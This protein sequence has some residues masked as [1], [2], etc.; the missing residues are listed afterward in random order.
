VRQARFGVR[1]A[2]LLLA[3]ACALAGCSSLPKLDGRMTTTALTDTAD[4]RLGR[5]VHAAATAHP[6]KS[7]IFPLGIPQDAFAARVVLARAAER[8]LDVQYYIWHGDTTG[9]LLLEELWNAAER[10]VRVR[11]LVDDNGVAGLDPALTALDSH[12]NVEVRL[13]NPF[14][15]RSFKALGFLTDFDRL[16]RRMHN[17]SLTADTQAAIVGGRNVGDEYFGAGD[18]MVFADLDV[19][20]V[21]PVAREVGAAFDLYWNSE[22]V[23][24]AEAIIGPGKPDGVAAMKAKFA[25]VRDSAEAAAYAAAVRATPLIEKLVEQKLEIEWVPVRL[26]YDEPGKALGETDD[27]ELLFSRLTRTVGE[28]QRE[29]DLVSPYFVPGKDGTRAL[30][31]LPARGVRL[32]IVTNSLAATD[33]GA[34]HSGYAKRRE[35]LLHGGAKIY[36]LKPDARKAAA[37]V[38]KQRAPGVFGSNAASLHA[39]T[40]AI[41]RSRVFVG[42]FNFDPRSV[43]LNTE[44]GLVIESPR[45]A[46]ALS[47]GLDQTLER[48]SYEVVLGKNGKLEWVERT[49]QGEVPY[50]SEPNTGFFRRLGVGFMSLLPIEGML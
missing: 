15:N 7:G 19:L 18:Q 42:S 40:F 30:A 49:D 11:L 28:P 41:D 12:Q 48:T 6:D 47:S 17:K 36:E 14:V 46:D 38:A 23:Y 5:A 33:V 1:T 31:A 39:K 43:R 3:V 26:V 21:G 20:A 4:T 24:P 25:A 50:H 9:F 44:M 13:F 2:A 10:G 27:A 32:R 8:S 35:A 34:V 37:G 29:L 22:V 45:L 16:N